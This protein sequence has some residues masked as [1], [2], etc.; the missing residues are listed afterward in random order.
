MGSD[1]NTNDAER[2]NKGE[3]TGSFPSE[4]VTYFQDR[5]E[6]LDSFLTA[7]S[8]RVGEYSAA[9]YSPASD[10]DNSE[11]NVQGLERLNTIIV[12][13]KEGKGDEA[14]RFF[15]EKMEPL[16]LDRNKTEARLKGEYPDDKVYR[17]ARVVLEETAKEKR[18]LEA[19]KFP[20]HHEAMLRFERD[21]RSQLETT[22][23]FRDEKSR[24]EADL[25][26]GQL[27]EMVDK[28]TS[29]DRIN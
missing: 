22:E 17:E 19:D 1:V 8:F 28:L 13:L 6:S 5:A 15:Y 23:R 4:V 2:D 12:G 10:L 21:T 3:G 9:S 18:E 26:L 29:V 20:L 16:A 27:K 14:V 11:R 25:K 7:H 24:D